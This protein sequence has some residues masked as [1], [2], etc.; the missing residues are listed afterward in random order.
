M[1]KLLTPNN[2]TI[3]LKQNLIAYWP[4]GSGGDVDL[5]CAFYRVAPVDFADV[6]GATWA[7]GPSNNLRD[8]VNFNGSTQTWVAGDRNFLAPGRLPFSLEI[9]INPDADSSGGNPQL[10]AG[11]YRTT[12]NN[13]SYCFIRTNT[14]LFFNISADGSAVVNPNFATALSAGVWCYAVATWD[15]VNARLYTNGV[16][17]ATSA[18]A[19]PVFAGDAPFTLAALG[20]D[21]PSLFFDGKLSE[22]SLVIGTAF[23]AEEVAWRYNGGQGRGLSPFRSGSGIGLFGAY[24][25]S[26]TTL[27]SFVTFVA[28]GIGASPQIL[29]TGGWSSSSLLTAIQSSGIPAMTAASVVLI[30]IND[31]L[32]NVSA[33]TIQGNLEDIIGLVPNARVVTLLPFGGYENWTSDRETVRQAVNSWI[34]ANAEFPINAEAMGE[35]SPPALTVENASA[36]GLHLA[37]PVGDTNLA[38]I[39]LAQGNW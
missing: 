29:A 24:G 30:G 4:L 20:N 10:I 33:A 2:P 31:V 32:A 22:H 9:W 14:G 12:N 6:G 38:N 23:S 3:I 34:M 7:A 15:G 19:G 27:P 21:T 37:Y 11:R 8:A 13:R 28:D 17:R 39:I 25:D 35:G 18:F 5:R 1:N 36:D 26:F 16:L